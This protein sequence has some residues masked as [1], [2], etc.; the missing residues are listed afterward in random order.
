MTV[1]HAC[2]EPIVGSSRRMAPYDVRRMLTVQAG[3]RT[4]TGRRYAGGLQVGV[5]AANPARSRSCSA[6]AITGRSDGHRAGL[7]SAAGRNSTAAG[8]FLALQVRNRTSSPH[9]AA[10]RGEHRRA[11]RALVYRHDP[12]L[13][14]RTRRP[15]LP[16]PGEPEERR[17]H[18]GIGNVP[19]QPVDAQL[20]LHLPPGFKNP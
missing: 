14:K 18:R 2:Y 16:G 20:P 6:S 7:R 12:G 8:S 4:A 10:A 13:G 17:I 3:R 15:V 19:L 5:T 11:R 9:A 1:L